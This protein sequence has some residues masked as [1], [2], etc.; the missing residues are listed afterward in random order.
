[1]FAL[2]AGAIVGGAAL[3]GLGARS[4]ANTAGKYQKRMMAKMDEEA[5]R[6]REEYA[7]QNKA[8]YN[9]LAGKANRRYKRAGKAMQGYY[10]RLATGMRGEYD[11]AAEG[12]AKDFAAEGEAA[13]N[14]YYDDVSQDLRTTG[15]EGMMGI[16]NN[17]SG[18]RDDAAYKF[19]QN[20]AETS[21]SR[22]AG[23]RGMGNSSN[24]M[25]AL[26]ERRL[27]VADTYLNSI[28]NRYGAA[29]GL[30]ETARTQG[31]E[32][33]DQYTSA[34][35][36]LSGSLQSQGLAFQG[37]ARSAGVSARSNARLQGVNSYLQNRSIGQQAYQSTLDAGTNIRVG[38]AAQATNAQYAQNMGAAAGAPLMVLG[39]GLGSLGSFALM[40]GF[41]NSYDSTQSNALEGIL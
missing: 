19:M 39:Q 3:S 1:M 15:Y 5:K 25:N 29:F 24:V 30:G 10:N 12:V 23:A 31:L 20:E 40:G 9:K 41:R 4:A 34:G 38:Q 2:M 26:Q 16:L 14:R 21:T 37:Q 28:M 32:A 17:P 27:N 18:V 13:Y 7:P 33:Q 11:A 35:L 8:F 22:L 6:Y 36:G